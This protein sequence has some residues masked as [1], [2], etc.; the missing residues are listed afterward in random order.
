MGFNS[1]FKGLI[2]VDLI[3][4][5]RAVRS[6]G[7]RIQSS[8]YFSGAH[9]SAVCLRHSSTSRNI[10]SS[11][12][13]DVIG[14]FHCRNPSGHIVALWSTQSLNRT[15]YHEYF[16]VGGEGEWL[17]AGDTQGWQT[18][19]LRVPIVIKSGSVTLL[20]TSGSVQTCTGI[21]LLFI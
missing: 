21:A 10:G 2:F 6:S 16:L 5:F 11:I 8:V 13:G 4:I 17:K 9:C 19:H 3:I 1:A 20:E 14:I 7:D 12:P 18:Y 15:E